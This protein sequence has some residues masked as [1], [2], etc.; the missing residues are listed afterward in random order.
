[1]DTPRPTWADYEAAAD[2]L[3]AAYAAR[4]QHE[5]FSPEWEACEPAIEAAHAEIRR[6]T[7][8]TKR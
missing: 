3:D 4:R 1:M 5:M 6:L 7:E 2:Q 8:A